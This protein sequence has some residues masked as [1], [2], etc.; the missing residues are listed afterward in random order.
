MP[1]RRYTISVPL[2]KRAPMKRYPRSRQKNDKP[3]A[4]SRRWSGR[5]PTAKLKASAGRI[6]DMLQ[7]LVMKNPHRIAALEQI[8]REMLNNNGE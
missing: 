8:V 6:V 3:Y 2:P 4:R 7:E 5:T 1:L